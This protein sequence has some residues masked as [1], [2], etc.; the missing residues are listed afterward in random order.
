[1]GSS[2]TTFSP[3]DSKSTS[4]TLPAPSCAPCHPA[5]PGTSHGGAPPAALGARNPLFFLFWTLIKPLSVHTTDGATAFI[6]LQE[7]FCR[8]LLIWAEL[9]AHHKIYSSRA[10]YYI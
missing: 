9:F 4:G 7:V 2:R 1:P 10:T 5:S 6:A 3:P 8:N